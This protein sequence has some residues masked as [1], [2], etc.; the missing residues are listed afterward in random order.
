MKP[1]MI[2]VLTTLTKGMAVLS[3][4]LMMTSI[5][6]SEQT[7]NCTELNKCGW[8]SLDMSRKGQESVQLTLRYANQ[9]SLRQSGYI[10]KQDFP[11][12]QA[13]P[14]GYNSTLPIFLRVEKISDS[15][16]IT[17]QKLDDVHVRYTGDG[18]FYTRTIESLTPNTS[19][20]AFAY[21]KYE[22]GLTQGYTYEKP[23]VKICFKTQ[24][25]EGTCP[26]GSVYRWNVVT[27][28]VFITCSS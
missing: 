6:Y 2:Q 21:A 9:F 19:Y 23:F 27:K 10:S 22:G 18:K 20:T 28:S 5:A 1:T 7:T 14:P 4:M 17:D 15:T 11:R 13:G 12:W 24:S 26:Q 8:C 25:V 16:V 3:L